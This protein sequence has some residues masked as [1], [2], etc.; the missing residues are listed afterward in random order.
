MHLR[1]LWVTDFR[2][3]GSVDLELPDGFTAVLGPNGQGKSNLLEAAGYL[4]T[5]RSFR[6]AGADALVRV[7]EERAV[8][9]GEV[10]TDG[11]EHLIEAEIS[12]AGR[13]RALLDRQRLGRQRDLL[14]V[15]RTTVFAPDDLELVKGGPALRRAF[16]DDLLVVLHPRHDEVRSDWERSL[17]QRNALLKQ[18]HGRPDASALMTLDVWDQ[19]ASAAGDELARLRSG[20]TDRIAG[21]VR[22]AYREVAGE[23]L[24][25]GLR[26][27]SPWRGDAFDP[28]SLSEALASSREEELR[29]GVTLVGPHRDELVLELRGMPA[30]THASQGEQRSLALALRL[31]SHRSVTE[32]Y[33]SP[34]VLLLDDVFSELDGARSSALLGALPVGQTLLS[35]AAGLPD[36][37]EADLVIDVEQG[38]VSVRP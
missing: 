17:R 25:V 27:E 4:L 10:V 35:S 14:A 29:R 37:I 9:R 5:L 24:D 8:V 38:A 33:G 36:G 34:P 19:K 6:G 23:D 15:A 12:R 11:R 7:G 30:R 22:T 13:S 21:T 20:L 32:A 2:S 18:I 31:A 26:Y 28:R 1:H 3:Y 16:L